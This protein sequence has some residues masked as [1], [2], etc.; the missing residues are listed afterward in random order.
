VLRRNIEIE[1]YFM[2]S[3]NLSLSSVCGGNCIFCPSQRLG[4]IKT[5]MMSPSLVQKIVNETLSSPYLKTV[6]HVNVGEMGDAFLNP[7]ALDCLR[8]IRTKLPHCIIHLTINFAT[9]TKEKSRQILE[10]NLADGVS[11]NIDGHNSLY[12]CLVKQGLS[13][14]KVIENV[15]DFLKLRELY[16]S[17]MKF[18][19]YVLS[20]RLYVNSIRNNHGFLPTKLHG[21]HHPEI[22]DD[23]SLVK[24]MWRPLLKKEDKINIHPT[25]MSWAERQRFRNA[26]INY[27]KYTCPKLERIKHE[28]FI[29]PD[30]TLYP[31]CIDADNELVFGDLTSDSITDVALSPERIKLIWLLEHRRFDEIGSKNSPCR[32]VNCCQEIHPHKIMNI[33]SRVPGYTFAMVAK[34]KVTIFM[35]GV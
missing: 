9:L 32:T 2:H 8:I 4:R 24:A 29:A 31:C 20:Y 16:R 11:G 5:K 28:I 7:D 13:Y 18:A 25:V 12:Y 22:E 1:K 19:I 21:V 33:V 34:K 14:E 30:G 17:K 27:K 3:I 6:R 23:S 35:K 26:K 10:E 15:R